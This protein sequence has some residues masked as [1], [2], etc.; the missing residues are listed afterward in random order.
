MVKT[1]IRYSDY[2]A[3]AIQ[4]MRQD[5]LLLVIADAARA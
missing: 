5:G 3:Q 4:R 1:T 2:F